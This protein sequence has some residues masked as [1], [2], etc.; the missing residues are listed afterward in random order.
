MNI[1]K[2]EVQFIMAL[3][4]ILE[5]EEI[6]TVDE[7]SDDTIQQLL[8]DYNISEKKFTQI[9]KLMTEDVDNDEEKTFIVNYKDTFITIK[10]YSVTRIYLHNLANSI[11]DFKENTPIKILDSKTNELL[12]EYFYNLDKTRYIWKK[13]KNNKLFS[14][15]YYFIKEWYD[16]LD[17]NDGPAEIIYTNKKNIYKFYCQDAE[18][19][20]KQWLNVHENQDENF[21]KEMLEKYKGE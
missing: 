9:K 17:R 5:H 3:A 10:E 16:S 2:N 4:R 19:S 18:Y 6:D 8:E 1:N 14:E 13:Y 7:I 11:S 20:L 15:Q 21:K 12:E